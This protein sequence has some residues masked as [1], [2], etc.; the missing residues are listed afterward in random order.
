MHLMGEY[1]DFVIP[2]N[3]AF[4]NQDPSVPMISTGACDSAS[5]RKVCFAPDDDNEV[6]FGSH[7][8]LSGFDC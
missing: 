6:T 3:S 1:I 2:G 8:L 4:S 5:A 7:Q